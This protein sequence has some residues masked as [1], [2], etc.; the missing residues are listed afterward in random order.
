MT[1]R[2]SI[3]IPVDPDQYVVAKS[4][5]NLVVN[6]DRLRLELNNLEQALRTPGW[7][8]PLPFIVSAVPLVVPAVLYFME[9]KILLGLLFGVPSTV[10]IS[11]FMVLGWQVY[12]SREK[13]KVSAEDTFRKLMSES[14]GESPV[15]PNEERRLPTPFWVR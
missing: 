2:G 11:V 14:T 15:E 4:S 10:L 12:R 1:N 13:R 7:E 5:T 9:S 8:L 6:E 3:Q